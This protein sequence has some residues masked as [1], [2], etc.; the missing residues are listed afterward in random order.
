[1]ITAERT[2]FLSRMRERERESKVLVKGVFDN[3]KPVPPRYC[4]EKLRWGSVMELELAPSRID[5]N[6]AIGFESEDDLEVHVE[7]DRVFV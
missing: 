4:G 3:S 7:L 5:R 6:F 1:M 2:L